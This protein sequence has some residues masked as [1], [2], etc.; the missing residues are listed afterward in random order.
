MPSLSNVNMSVNTFFADCADERK[1]QQNRE[2][3]DS[4]L[5]SMQ[6]LTKQL[7][8]QGHDITLT[9]KSTSF[10]VIH[11]LYGYEKIEQFSKGYE[12][13]LKHMRILRDFMSNEKEIYEDKTA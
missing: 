6:W 4:L 9:E 10:T 3:Y 5:G 8:T 2:L 12:G 13:D 1:L 11:S 7:Y